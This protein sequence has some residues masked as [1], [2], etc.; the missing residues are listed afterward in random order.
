M[1]QEKPLGA[2]SITGSS[3]GVLPM[4]LMR[5]RP[6]PWCEAGST[7]GPPCSF[8]EKSMYAAVPLPPSDHWA[9]TSPLSLESAPY[10]AALV[11]NSCTMRAKVC[12]PDGP[13][14]T[15]GPE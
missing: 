14:E 6:K 10:F 8:Q 7:A 4:A 9:N 13:S 3:V 12:T 5:D 11:H 2:K 1:R 15:C